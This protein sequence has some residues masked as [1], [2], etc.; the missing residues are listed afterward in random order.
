[1]TVKI[2]WID[3]FLADLLLFLCKKLRFKLVLVV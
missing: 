1:M 3:D 2:S